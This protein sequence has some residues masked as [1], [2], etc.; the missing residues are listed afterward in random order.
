MTA[1]PTSPKPLSRAEHVYSE[2]RTR[3][4]SGD[5]RGGEWVSIRDVAN[6]L[7]VSFAPVSDAFRRL[8]QQG[9]LETEPGRGCRVPEPN[10]ARLR[11]EFTLRT[12]L[13]TEAARRAALAEHRG[14]DEHLRQLARMLDACLPEGQEPAMREEI[15]LS[16]RREIA[17]VSR[18]W[19]LERCL[20]GAWLRIRIARGTTTVTPP[21]TIVGSTHADLIEAI[22]ARDA[23][24]AGALAR[25]HCCAA[26]EHQLSV[27]TA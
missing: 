11:D 22:D 18:S 21:P 16:F 15:D 24:R 20:Q 10:P 5:I 4:L 14:P 13:E 2:L 12:A 3:I 7:G 8:E 25:E 19:S 23:D 27:M 9:L 6:T 1:A 26:M 17:R